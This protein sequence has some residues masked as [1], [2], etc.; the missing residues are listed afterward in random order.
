MLSVVHFLLWKL[1]A[2]C[3]GS[4]YMWHVGVCER[5]TKR[6]EAK[7]ASEKWCVWLLVDLGSAFHLIPP[8][9]PI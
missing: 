3:I 6:S 1:N 7:D 5:A 9:P 4:L 8:F 2:L